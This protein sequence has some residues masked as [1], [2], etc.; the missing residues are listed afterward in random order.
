MQDVY[1]LVF[2]Q[3]LQEDN[4]C[5]VTLPRTPDHQIHSCTGR[6][7]TVLSASAAG[8]VCCNSHLPAR[9]IRRSND[10]C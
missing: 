10:K 7:K 9:F 1:T 4:T 6:Q 2:Q 3:E 5:H 8:P